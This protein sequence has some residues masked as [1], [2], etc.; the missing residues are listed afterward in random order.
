[1]PLLKA[2]LISLTFLKNNHILE[3]IGLIILMIMRER[4]SPNISEFIRYL[5]AHEEAEQGLPT[6]TELSQ[7]LGVSV[8]SLR[9]QLEVARALGLAEVQP[10]RGMT[11]R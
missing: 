8:A 1:M 9:E 10:E 3:L 11:R 4:V 6:L 2:K 7:E 5:A